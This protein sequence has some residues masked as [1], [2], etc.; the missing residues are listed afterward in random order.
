M[1]CGT[2]LA[3][4][5]GSGNLLKVRNLNGILLPFAAACAQAIGN[6]EAGKIHAAASWLRLGAILGQKT[7]FYAGA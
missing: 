3:P 1:E 2:S 5:L 4:L 7:R 6:V